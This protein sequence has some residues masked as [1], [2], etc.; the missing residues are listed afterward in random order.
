MSAHL[1]LQDIAIRY[2]NKTIVEDIS[3]ALK[4]GEIGCLLGPSGCGKTTLLRTIAGFERPTHGKITLRG[5]EV[6][7]PSLLV[8]PEKRRVGMV[9][10]DYALFPH[11]TI[12]QNIAFG[13]SK[14]SKPEQ[15][16]RVDALL[17]LIGLSHTKK[18]YPH[19][20]SGGQQQRIALARALAPKPDILLLDEPFSN[21]DVELREHLVH[22]VRQLIKSE[23]VT[24]IL[25]THDQ[26][27]A[28]A[29]SDKIA[30]LNDGKL[31]QWGSADELYDQPN[32]VFS[33]EFIGQGTLIKG[34]IKK[35]NDGTNNLQTEIGNL[36]I[37]EHIAHNDAV[38]LLIRP[39]RIALS[40]NESDISVTLVSKSFRGGHYLC[41][42]ETNNKQLL[43]VRLPAQNTPAPGAQLFITVSLSNTTPII[44]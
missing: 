18:R 19:Q 26:Q 43:T 27:E 22:D 42:L 17:T 9:F 24:A 21:L 2:A 4:E 16:Q 39:D 36:T 20:L 28:F 41:S 40:N 12:E 14:Q 34:A 33:A 5:N 1:I 3:F 11:L 38:K 30:L 31:I 32:S 35:G 13:L 15:L 44:Y 10:Q 7:S 37:P 23:K 29:T 25:V 8:P 6:A